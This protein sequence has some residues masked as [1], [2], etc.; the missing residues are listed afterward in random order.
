MRD[1]LY[2]HNHFV[3]QFKDLLENGDRGIG[4]FDWT[5]VQI[6]WPGIDFSGKTFESVNFSYAI[7]N[8]ANFSNVTLV[9]CDLSHAKLRGANMTGVTMTNVD[10]TD[11]DFTSALLDDSLKNII[12]DIIT[13]DVR[14]C[15]ER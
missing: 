11:C 6:D 8:G 13:E 3:E 14:K 10:L 2:S 7:L 4:R 1:Q 12:K 9:N 5:G 15:N